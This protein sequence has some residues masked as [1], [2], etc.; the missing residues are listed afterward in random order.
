MALPVL[1]TGGTGFVG[2]A[3]VDALQEKHP[4]WALTVLDLRNPATA[5]SQVK[6]LNGDIT[7]PADVKEAFEV[8]KPVLLIHTAGLVPALA[9]R[10]G[11]KDRDKVFKVN[12][13]GTRNMLDA[14]KENGVKAF[15]WTG[16]CTAVT[17]DLKDQYPNVDER[18]PTSKHS[19]IYGESKVGALISGPN[20]F[21]K[22]MLIRRPPKP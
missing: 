21:S 1:I 20:M 8:A 22:L 14:A 11:R 15:V 19:L 5:R 4:E 7:L 18:W 2:S 6:Y 9:E 12:V 10:Y 16:S 13:E 3:I 17:D